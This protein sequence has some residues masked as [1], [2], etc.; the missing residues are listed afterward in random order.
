MKLL[1]TRKYLMQVEISE[2][3]LR[4]FQKPDPFPDLVQV[5]RYYIL[6]VTQENQHW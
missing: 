5:K 1:H 3:L 6:A 2:L 4:F